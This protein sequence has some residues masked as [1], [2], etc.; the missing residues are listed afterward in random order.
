LVVII[1]LIILPLLK[2]NKEVVTPEI[3]EARLINAIIYVESSGNPKAK[4]HKG[5]VG[6]MQIMPKVWYK[7]LK[8]EGIINVKKDLY[9]PHKNIES[10]KYI[11][12]HYYRKTNGDLHKTLYLYSGKSK[13]YP[14][15]VMDKYYGK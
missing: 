12:T 14:K 6:L 10:G 8:K 11:L 1:S 4:S 2:E 7:T 15:K 9:I 5:A 13:H 3:D